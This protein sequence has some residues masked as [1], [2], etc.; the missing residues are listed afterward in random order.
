M[1]M[2][3]STYGTGW[4]PLRILKSLPVQEY[5]NQRL[6][7]YWQ[8]A[9]LPRDW[10]GPI[11]S[12]LAEDVDEPE[13]ALGQV[14]KRFP[15]FVETPSPF[16]ERLREF[17]AS[18]VKH[19]I[20]RMAPYLRGDVFLDFGGRT[21]DVSESVLREPNT[22]QYAYVTDIA[23]FQEESEDPRIQLVW[24]SEGDLVPMEDEFVDVA[25]ASMVLH[26]I[27]RMTRR[28]L[29]SKLTKMIKPDGR[30]ILIEDSYPMMPDRIEHNDPLALEFM[31]FTVDERFDIIGFF[32][33]FGNTVTRNR[34]NFPYALTYES[35]DYWEMLFESFGYQT[36]HSE[37]I[38]FDKD[39]LDFM[40]PKAFMVFERADVPNP[41]IS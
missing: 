34:R 24:Q 35:M 41:H 11:V 25:L 27:N 22:I 9:D 10:V 15:Q 31:K 40:P 1:K 17:R 30:I 6:Q 28:R 38:P 16:Q 36:I 21:Q 32:D 7:L 18:K 29:L 3:L 8:T 2:D 14:F 5:V 4:N 37:F 12:L 20:Q 26:H 23:Q 39:A 19:M 33:W 13:R